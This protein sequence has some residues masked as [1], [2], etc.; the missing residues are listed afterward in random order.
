MAQ[1]N[2]LAFAGV[3]PPAHY[4]APGAKIVAFVRS[5]GALANDFAEVA[6]R[7]VTT[8]NAGLAR[9]RAGY[10]D[11]VVVMPGHTENISVADQMSSLI[12]GTRIIGMGRGTQRPT[13][14]WTAATS[15]FLLDVANCTIE[16]CIL[17]LCDAGNGGVTVANPITVT[18]AGCG[19]LGCDIFF[20]ADANDI[21]GTAITLTAATDFEFHRNHC[22]G[23]TAGV[24]TNFM[25]IAAADRLFMSD[26]YIEGASNHA[27]TGSMLRF[28]TT[29]SLNIR[30]ERNSY[31]NRLASSAAVVIGFAGVSG[32]SRDEHFA[33]L[34]TSTLTPWLTSTGI[35]T[36][37][38][39][40][41]ADTAGQ[42]GTE[43]V[44]TVSS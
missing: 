31:T 9:C 25:D 20:G 41:V 6:D 32:V 42:T 44:G 4:L 26:N 21:V 15:S 14:T 29:A 28:H 7:T 35:M 24:C 40:T 22:V 18:G 1:D 3:P 13:F 11:V 23:A 2:L 17:K 37:H 10:G 16:N 33:Y 5:G 36:F 39:P 43:V 12:A 30:L 19:I 38:R 8:L 27:S 34:I